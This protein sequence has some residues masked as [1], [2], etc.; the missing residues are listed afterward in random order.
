MTFMTQTLVID[1]GSQLDGAFKI[2]VPKQ[3]L[4]TARLPVEKIYI[5]KFGKTP[6]ARR[7]IRIELGYV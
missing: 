2:R 1:W 4:R 3:A 6:R 5:M 7:T